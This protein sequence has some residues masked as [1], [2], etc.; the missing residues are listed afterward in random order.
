MTQLIVGMRVDLFNSK[1]HVC[2][3]TK[4]YAF[5]VRLYEYVVVTGL[6][7]KVNVCSCP[8]FTVEPCCI[9]PSYISARLYFIYIFKGIKF[10]V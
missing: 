10:K 1:G 7:E 6:Y 2:Y 4:M 5:T 3:A 8:G 9:D